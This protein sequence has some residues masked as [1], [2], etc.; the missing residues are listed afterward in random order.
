MGSAIIKQTPKIPATADEDLRDIK[1]KEVT[2]RERKT[3]GSEYNIQG[4]S[5]RRILRK[6]WK[7]NLP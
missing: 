2:V 5:A 6:G 1:S 7:L 4:D 3:C